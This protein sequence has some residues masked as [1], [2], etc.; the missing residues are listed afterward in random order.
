LTQLF[1]NIGIRLYGLVIRVAALFNPKAKKWVD[2]REDLLLKIEQEVDLFSG[3]TIWVHCASL[4]EFEM[5]RPIIE[6]LKEADANLRIVLTFFSPSGFEV[7][8]NYLGADHVFYLS[9][10]TVSNA[11]RFVNIVKPSKVIF[12]KY[13]LWFHHLN[14]AKELGSKL[15]LISASFHKGQSYFRFYGSIGRKTLKLFDRIFL[16]DNGSKR[17]L[18]E[19]GITNNTVCGDTRYDRVM[20]IAQKAEVVPSIEEFKAQYKL[21]I[22]GST[23]PEDERLLTKCIDHFPNTKW[24]IAPH[25]IGEQNLQRLEKM[26]PPSARL[27]NGNIGSV[28]VMIVDSIGQLNKMYKYADAAYIGGGFK[29]GLHNILEA[30]AFGVPAVF[31]PD[32]SRFPD[33]SEMAAKGLA[34]SIGHESELRSVLEQLISK[35][36]SELRSSI[37]AFMQSRVGATRAILEYTIKC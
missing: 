27:S 17:L 29:T 22:C 7:R 9:L 28:N 23:W 26:L 5:A 10:D 18:D 35:D 1:Y 12:V 13:D 2:G 15:L 30:T 4:G 19:L 25:E 11:K 33:A 21:V 14:E 37:A 24:V 16:V 31:G 3:E 20:E 8:K 32:S 34:F 36:Q 6:R